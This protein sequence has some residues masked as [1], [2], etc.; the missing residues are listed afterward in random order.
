MASY[1][2]ELKSS[3]DKDLRKLDPGV[4]SR[5]AKQLDKLAQDPFPPGVRKLE[6]TESFYRIR[7]GDYRLIYSVHTDPSLIVV[8]YV[9]HRR[10]A[11][12]R[13]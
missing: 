9:R 8:H 2:I 11:Y 13:L 10:E 1:R 3:A 5:I 7:V 12:R 4:I 6:R